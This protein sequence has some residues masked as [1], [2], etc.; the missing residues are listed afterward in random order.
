MEERR[1]KGKEILNYYRVATDSIV[2]FLN[3]KKEILWSHK[4]TNS[5]SFICMFM[6]EGKTEIMGGYRDS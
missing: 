4:V 5:F 3:W 2:F 1:L 6:G